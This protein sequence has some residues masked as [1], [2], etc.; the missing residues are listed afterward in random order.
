MIEEI[1]KFIAENM[2]LVTG[3]FGTACGF[4]VKFITD[5]KKND[6][7]ELR[8]HAD[9]NHRLMEINFEAISK[10]LEEY[11]SSNE[12]QSK[13]IS[14]LKRIVSSYQEDIK[15]LQAR[16]ALTEKELEKANHAFESADRRATG[17]ENKAKKA[18]DDLKEQSRK[19]EESLKKALKRIS[20]LESEVRTLRGQMDDLSNNDSSN[21]E[22]SSGPSM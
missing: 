20:E 5:M 15:G 4:A 22:F 21:T 10:R 18:E 12:S 6:I 11:K 7:D 1:Q 19:S 14:D 2:V 8:V 16:L 3:A 17:A 13:E 9:R